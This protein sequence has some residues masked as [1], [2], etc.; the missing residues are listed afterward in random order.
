MKALILIGLQVD[1]FPLGAVGIEGSDSIL[2][3]VNEWIPQ[4]EHVVAACFSHPANHKMFVANYPWR[5]PGQEIDLMGEKIIL[6]NY[7]CIE[8]SFGAEL[9]V[10]FDHNKITHKV[11]MGTEQRLM[12]RS[13]FFDE[14][15]KQDTGLKHYLTNNR[16]GEIYLAGLPFEEGVYQ[17][18]LD[19]IKEGLVVQI[20]K[21]ATKWKD[22]AKVQEAT[23]SLEKRGVLF[24]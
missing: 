15:H 23:K 24:L 6:K 22:E 1:L 20:I 10:G 5:R 8:N 18:A 16:V 3:V 4:F 9:M 21:N 2:P 13:A 19:G 14:N 7:H 12:P 17:T 11:W